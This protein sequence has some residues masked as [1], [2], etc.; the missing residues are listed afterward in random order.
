[1][2]RWILL[3]LFPIALLGLLPSA[4]EAHT[5]SS[6]AYSD[7]TYEHGMIRYSLKIDLYDLRTTATPEDPDISSETPEVLDRF[8]SNSKKEVEALLL[9]KIKLYADGLPLQGRLTQL[10][11]TEVEG[12]TQKFAE[13]ILEYPIG[14]APLQFKLDYELVYDGDQWHVNY[15]DLSLGDLQKTGVI[16]S[17]LRTLE[18]GQMSPSYAMATYLKLG[19]KHVGTT[20]GAAL[21]VIAL[22][23]GSRTLKRALLIVGTFAAALVPTLLLSVLKIV[24]LPDSF[25]D[26]TAALGILYTALHILLSRNEKPLLWLS[27]AFGLLFGFQFGQV[28]S[29]SNLSGSLIADATVSFLVGIEAGLVL[30][31]LIAYPASRFAQR[32]KR[33]VPAALSAIALGG[34]VLLLTDAYL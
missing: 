29:G 25:V 6:L 11:G 16:V 4:V 26:V 15:V 32:F 10:H 13:A 1:M 33:A 31:A 34:L 28:L 14:H 2:R 27:A 7:I 5:N 21:L 3:L 23:I 20:P 8:Y 19:L 17:D 30:A 12:E 22:I 24:M 9:S 18:A